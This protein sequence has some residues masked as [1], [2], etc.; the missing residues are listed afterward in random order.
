MSK[1]F[2]K[3]LELIPKEVRSKAESTRLRFKAGVM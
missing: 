3:G 2:K 1:Q